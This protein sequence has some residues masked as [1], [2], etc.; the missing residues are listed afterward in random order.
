MNA[1]SEMRSPAD[2]GRARPAG[3][4]SSL[5]PR[6]ERALGARREGRGCVLEGREEGGQVGARLQVLDREDALRDRRERRRGRDGRADALLE[7]EAAQARHGEDDG[8]VLA[9]I[10]LGEPRVHVAAQRAEGKARE[11]AA[12]LAFAP[13][14]RGADDRAGG[15]RR[16]RFVSRGHERIERLLAGAEGRE[17]EPR[18]QLHGNVLQRMHRDV[19][20][21]LGERALE[22][23]HEQALPAHLRERPVEDAIAA[24]G[25]ADD[26]DGEAG[27]ALG[28]RGGN[29]VRLPHREL[30][31]A[32]GDANAVGGS[33][34]EGILRGKFG[35]K[36]YHATLRSMFDWSGE[37]S[38]AALF[39]S[40]FLSATVLPGNSE[41]VL[42]AVLRAYPS[43][44]AAALALATVGNTLGSMTTY[45]LGRLVP[46]RA[47]TG[48][49]LA[50]IR[51]YGAFALVSRG[52]PWRAMRSASAAGAARV[53]WAAALGGALRGETSP[54]S[55]CRTSGSPVLTHVHE[56]TPARD[57]LQLHVVLRPR[58]RHPPSRR[59]CVGHARGAARRA[60]HRDAPA[61]MLYEVLGDIWVV[62]RN[63]YLQDD[64][65][66][67]PR[68]LNMLVGAMHH[69]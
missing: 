41:V 58:D 66:D 15:H 19:G 64:L 33:A 26:F 20:A 10:E 29:H 40:S 5:P 59:G 68:R 4:R 14:A 55:G 7:P 37:A 22:L 34:H 56:R 2:L 49:S 8:V 39:V 12:Q 38:L 52:F 67:S 63:P 42:F 27:R 47:S 65:L 31:L 11:R 1:S 24:R 50:W 28:K 60:P 13:Q 45:A 32:R 35:E 53:R 48:R 16:E 30:A 61:R 44:L 62:N 36:S 17:R 51:R 18:R 25:D 6:A 69:R 57:P 46:E 43:Q 21:V 54:L 3:R 23:L 9:A